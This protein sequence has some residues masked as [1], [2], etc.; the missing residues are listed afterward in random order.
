MRARLLC[1]CGLAALLAACS[2]GS[3]IV[4]ADAGSADV[5]LVDAAPGDAGL[6]D[7]APGQEA[8]T[9]SDAGSGADTG[10]G[11]GGQTDAAQADVAQADAAQADASPAEDASGQDAAIGA[12]AGAADAAVDAPSGYDASVQHAFHVRQ[13]AAGDGSDW[14]SALGALPAQLQRSA[15]YYVADGD[16]HPSGY[17]FDDPA[18]GQDLIIVRKATAADH[19]TDTGWDAAFGDGVAQFGPLTFTGAYTIFDGVFAYGFRVVGGYQ[20]FIVDITDTADHV[21]VRCSDLDGN[22]QTNASGY[23]TGGVCN[24]VDIT[25]S[26]VTLQANDIHNIA[27]DG[28]GV[29]GQ[30]LVFEGNRIHRLHGCGTDNGCGPC[31]NGHSDGLELNATTDVVMRGNLVY[32]I[33]STSALITGQFGPGD[34]TRDLVLENNIF[35]TPAVGLTV[36]LYYVQGAR[37]VNNVIWG[38]TQGTRYGGLSLGP[39]LTNL[40]LRNNIIL[41]INF[42]HLGGSFNAAEHRMHDNLYGMIDAGEYTAAADEI[43]G[44]PRFVNILMSGN[45]ADHPPDITAEDFR[46]QTGSPAIDR[47]DPAFAP[48]LDF[49]GAARVGAPDLG[50]IEHQ[51]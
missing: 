39:E 6:A 9:A 23:H 12:D 18:A 19:G 49:F 8:A 44:D 16:Y 26:Y 7:L 33:Q 30:H 2:N 48:A 1:G 37:V 15:I 21:T 36:Y 45:E 13:G 50:A 17:T 4:R 24:G 14:Q 51:P 3:S 41:N 31:Y 40:D 5:G 28:V 22:F 43:V 35:Y 34:Y 10:L 20:G 25:G 47:A 46:L 38:R 42:T 11:D 27:D 32:D 29:Y